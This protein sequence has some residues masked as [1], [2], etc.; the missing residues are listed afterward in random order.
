[1]STE[2]FLGSA[3]VAAGLLTEARLR[4]AEFRSVF[5][6][7]YV[8]A[9]VEDDL[10]LRSRAAAL[11]LPADGAL[12]GYSAAELHGVDCAPASAPAE[13]IA[14]TGSVRK[15]R[16]L[17]VR[18]AVLAPSEIDVVKGCRVTTPFRTAWDLGRRLRLTEAVAAIDGLCR[19][20]EFDPMAL[21]NGPPG[22]RGC[23]HL[24][25]AVLLANPLAESAMESRVRLLFHFAGLPE[26]VLQYR[27]FDRYG[28]CL[29]RFDLAYPRAKLAIEYDSADH[30][31][32][33]STEVVYDFVADQRRGV[34]V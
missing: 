9:D 29:A 5:R 32:V 30:F 8:A 11:L 14:P 34:G 15:R 28:V 12:C 7:V 22:A 26:P 10:D 24:A 3:A 21:L 23:R 33:T 4:T 27:L 2:P 17:I 18:Q 25:K 20:G 16:G 19:V 1:M 13:L 6:D 31:E